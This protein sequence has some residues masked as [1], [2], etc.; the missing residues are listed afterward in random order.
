MAL[1]GM[2]ASYI[3][4]TALYFVCFALAITTCGLYGTDLNNARK[5]NKYA[6]SKW[7]GCRTPLNVG[8]EQD[9]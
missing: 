8:G 7:V 2:T 6:D 3:G 9:G 4:F 1:G 5:V